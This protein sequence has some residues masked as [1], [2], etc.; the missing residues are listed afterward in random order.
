MSGS[1][2]DRF[3][4]RTGVGRDDYAVLAQIPLFSG[5]PLDA[6]RALL[7]DA[8]VQSFPRN[9]V[10]FLKDE[11]A[12][13][14]Y[15]VFDGWVKLFRT[16]EAGHET[17][18]NVFTRGES[19]A[20][21]AIFDRARYPV[22]AAVV[23][24][25]RLLVIPA[26]P[27]MRRLSENG[28]YALKVL[29]SMSRHLRSLVNQVE[30]LT[31]KSSTE[32]VAEFLLRLSPVFAGSATVQLPL[33]KALIAGRLGMQPETF[34]RALAKLRRVGVVSRGS[35]VTIPDV[36]ALRRLSEGAPTGRLPCA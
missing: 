5:L 27:F 31:M 26:D 22:S 29:A 32:R 33:D 25:S 2:R 4:R 13:R 20:E 6:L 18:I 8:W 1:D 10:L 30:R 11:P 35:E 34:S 9:F 15:V 16:T 24:D 7:A 12:I 14:C 36:M 28:E 23:E 19:F 21:A 3:E 17:V